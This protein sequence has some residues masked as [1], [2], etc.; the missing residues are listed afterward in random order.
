MMV[1]SQPEG[2]MVTDPAEGSMVRHPAGGSTVS[3]RPAWL[4]KAKPFVKVA[5]LVAK[6]ASGICPPLAICAEI[7]GALYTFLENVD[8]S[9]TNRE[10]LNQ[11]LEGCTT[12]LGNITGLLQSVETGKGCDTEDKKTKDDARG[13]LKK[14]AIKLE[15]FLEEIRKGFKLEL[16]VASDDAQEK[17]T[18]KKWY[19]VSQV[20]M[21]FKD[22]MSA[23]EISDKIKQYW[24]KYQKLVKE[25]SVTAQLV[26]T[27]KSFQILDMLD[28][29]NDE[30]EKAFAV[31]VARLAEINNNVKVVMANVQENK[32][33][34]HT[35]LQ[36]V[37]GLEK[38]GS[39]RSSGSTKSMLQ[40][41]ESS[42]ISPRY[43]SDDDLDITINFEDCSFTGKDMS[44]APV[45]LESSGHRWKFIQGRWQG[46]DIMVKI[47]TSD[48]SANTQVKDDQK[49]VLTSRQELSVWSRLQH[50]SV[51]RLFGVGRFSSERKAVTFAVAPLV[52]ENLDTYLNNNPKLSTRAKLQLMTDVARGM[53]FLH[54][55]LYIH[56]NLKP[57][58]ILVTENGRAMISD[59]SLALLK[60]EA[61]EFNA[62]QV[63]KHPR[64]AHYASPQRL[65]ETVGIHSSD[66]VYSF[67]IV[68]AAIWLQMDS[69]YGTEVDE[70]DIIAIK[71]GKLRPNI[72]GMPRVLRQIVEQCWENERDARPEFQ[73]VV[74]ILADLLDLCEGDR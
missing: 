15:V 63:K 45:A 35:I 57:G 55:R 34:L 24:K 13:A 28:R 46:Q 26:N 32:A 64:S 52:K 21:H 68:C 33:I 62:E 54:D 70:D 65:L 67:G 23:E 25:I 49:D 44:K 4:T 59:F 74:E 51:L 38:T 8:T 61:T 3:D 2:S 47:L 43:S 30:F 16:P 39:V 20:I 36:K 1:T 37:D 60:L 40:S 41:G 56:T 48:K 12:L 27:K 69:P 31:V 22:A 5:E 42:S 17:R 66:D 29:Q 73:V 71:L 58:N 6:T 72:S 18:K 11:L 53:N 19:Q 14:Q 10:I 50:P 7:L 9:A